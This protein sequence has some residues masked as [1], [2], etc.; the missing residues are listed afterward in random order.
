MQYEVQVNSFKCTTSYLRFMNKVFKQ[1]HPY[2]LLS[3]NQQVQLNDSFLDEMLRLNYSD[4]VSNFFAFQFDS[5]ANFC[6][7]AIRLLKLT[8]T[9]LSKFECGN[10]VAQISLK[11]RNPR[12]DPMLNM[13]HKYLNQQNF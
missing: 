5:A 7:F 3:P 12:F 6:K 1:D 10:P 8:N 2:L 11:C 9:L 4:L 13:I